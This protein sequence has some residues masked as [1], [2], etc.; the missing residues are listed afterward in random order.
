MSRFCACS[1]IAYFNR[2]WCNKIVYIRIS[3]TWIQGCRLDRVSKQFS[4]T[5]A[6]VKE[7]SNFFQRLQGWNNLSWP[8]QPKISVK[9]EMSQFV[10]LFWLWR[11]PLYIIKRKLA[12]VN[13]KLKRPVLLTKCSLNGNFYALISNN[14]AFMNAV[15]PKIP[16]LYKPRKRWFYITQSFFETFPISNE[17]LL[18]SRTELLRKTGICLVLIAWL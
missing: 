8:R 14:T 2:G 4:T 9:I 3:S 5:D 17:K 16:R 1:C 13:A 18:S 11:G 12:R 10:A 6:V 15:S 7:A